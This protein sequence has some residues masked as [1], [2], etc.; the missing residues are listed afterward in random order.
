MSRYKSQRTDRHREADHPHAVDIP[1]PGSGL[2][3]NLNNIIAAA[4]T[5]PGGAETWGHMTPGPKGDPQRWCRIG[6]KVPA[7]ADRMAALFS[8]LE[9]R[10]VR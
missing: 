5:L 2:G 10:R 1:I 7:D 6:T 8:H 4:A 9:A 3:Q